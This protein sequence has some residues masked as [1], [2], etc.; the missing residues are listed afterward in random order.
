MS[1][2]KIALSAIL[3]CTSIIAED[4]KLP[5]CSRANAYLIGSTEM[6]RGPSLDQNKFDVIY[7]RYQVSLDPDNNTTEANNLCRVRVID[8]SLTAVDLNFNDS[9][10]NSHPV[11]VHFVLNGSDTVSFTHQNNMLSIPLTIPYQVD[12]IIDFT[13]SYSIG[14]EL[15][16]N[17]CAFNWDIENG[18]DLI[19]TMSQP[20]DARHWWPCK[21]YPTDKIDSMDA[22]I[23]VPANLVV[24]SNGKLIS[25]MD[26]ADGTRTFHWRES[27]PIAT[28]LF[29]LAIYPYFIWQD[30]YIS[31]E[32]DTLPIMFYTFN[33]TNNSYPS[34]LVTNYKKTSDM[35]SAF[36]EMFGEYPFMDEKYG[37]AEWGASYGMEHQ[38][39]TS[40]GDPTERRVAHELAHMWWG[41][42][43]TLDSYH[44]M[45]LNEGFA[46]YAEALWAEHTGGSISYHSKMNSYAYYG[47]GTIYVEDPLNDNVFHFNLEYNKG[48]WVMHML[49]H[50]VGDA[51][52][53]EILRT[54]GSDLR[55]KYKTAT[56]EQFRDVC[57]TVSGLDLNAFFNQWIY[58]AYY[59]SYG[60][61]Y[62][63]D[64]DSV[65]LSISQHQTST[66][67]FDMPIDIKVVCFDTSYILILQNNSQMQ[68]YSFQLPSG[69]DLRNIIIDPN[70][71]ILKQ[72]TYLNTEE[73]LQNPDAFQLLPPYPN[74][75]NNQISLSIVLPHPGYLNVS[76]YDLRGY[77]VTTLLDRQMH[78]GQ[79]QLSWH[80][81]NVSSGVYILRTRFDDQVR[82]RKILLIK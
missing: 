25:D 15:Y 60:L 10:P 51:T 14:P 22:I 7:Y 64:G 46:R 62:Y 9:Y 31:A 23:T 49:R 13:I 43:I 66:V 4:E 19:W 77:H 57:E 63:Q 26:N 38:T 24:A 11:T 40:M 17:S 78:V 44:H 5:L 41:D 68:H 58:N 69:Q 75:F 33:D 59:P 16:C 29:S 61:N 30:E 82:T 67:I 70:G 53:F 42:M 71:W 21:D 35:L 8:T 81:D 39:L 50:V 79:L 37:H 12:D 34:Y 74:P 32:N 55:Y 80:A 72:V 76:V 56:T 54:Y 45:W 2:R 73:N 20:Y 6:A 28:Y 47:A 36:V 52:F 3:L 27:H 18:K 48:A 65:R 1:V